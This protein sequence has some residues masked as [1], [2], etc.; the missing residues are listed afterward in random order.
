MN[1]LSVHLLQNDCFFSA[2]SGCNAAGKR[3]W[4]ARTCFLGMLSS[5][6]SLSLCCDFQ[7]MIQSLTCVK[8]ERGESAVERKESQPQCSQTLSTVLKLSLS[9]RIHVQLGSFLVSVLHLL[10]EAFIMRLPMSRALF[11]SSMASICIFGPY[12][13]LRILSWSKFIRSTLAVRYNWWFT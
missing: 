3:D 8:N 2:M 9:L 1:T 5:P 6:T 7:C 12:I 10:S 11:S 4:K 13:V